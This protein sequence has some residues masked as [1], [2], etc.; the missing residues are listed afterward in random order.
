MIINHFWEKNV[1]LSDLD[2]EKASWDSWVLRHLAKSLFSCSAHKN[3]VISWKSAS[4]SLDDKKWK[5]PTE[6]L[7]IR[8]FYRV[9]KGFAGFLALEENKPHADFYSQFQLGL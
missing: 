5:Y 9:L 2:A 8:V 7:Q 4:Y 3:S 6:N 1:L